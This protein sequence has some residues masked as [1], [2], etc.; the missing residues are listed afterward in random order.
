M[1]TVEITLFPIATQPLSLSVSNPHECLINGYSCTAS[2]MPGARPLSGRHTAAWKEA[3]YLRRV[4]G[5]QVH[6]PAL[7][8]EEGVRT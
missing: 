1:R 5:Q 2:P 6:D 8:R 4:L 3:A 7:W